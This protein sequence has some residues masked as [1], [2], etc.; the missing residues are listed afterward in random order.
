MASDTHTSPSDGSL[1]LVRSG[2]DYFD[3]LLELINRAKEVIHLQ[4]YIF[5]ADET[6]LR[7]ISALKEAAVRGV[8]VFVVVD[9]FGSK[10]FPDGIKVDIER[11]G[12]I[13]KVFSPIG[14][15]N[16]LHLGRRMHHKIVVVDGRFCL[17]GGINVADKYCG[18]LGE[19][20]WL[21]FAILISGEAALK[22][23][24]ICDAILRRK[25]SRKSN[26]LPASFKIGDSDVRFRQN[27]WFRGKFQVTRGYVK[28]F[29]LARKEVWIVASYFLPNRA[30]R[31]ALR[32]AARNGAKI[33]LILPGQSDVPLFKSATS[34]LYQYLDKCGAE[35]YEWERSVLHGK[36]AMVDGQWTTIGSFNL[37]NLS[38]FGSIELN[39]EVTGDA[40]ANEVYSLLQLLTESGCKRI[41]P[42]HDISFWGKVKNYLSYELVR[43]ML[44]F[45]VF[46]PRYFGKG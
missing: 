21:D 40:H 12:I 28:R 32:K 39:V 7:V 43:L 19:E 2:V 37:N 38:V 15:L 26:G 22:G 11:V 4:T 1:R 20:P 29:S 35:I 44:K 42:G 6:G 18:A 17:V 30:I 3:T 36:L 9:G 16:L 41:L 8:K 34:H 10:D 24:Q 33:R 13:F 5:D 27:D 31:K 46:F 23:Q 25:L 14:E 45:L